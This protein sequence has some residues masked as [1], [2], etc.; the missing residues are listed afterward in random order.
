M[1]LRTI[2]VKKYQYYVGVGDTGAN[3]T[4]FTEVQPGIIQSEP[5]SFLPTNE[6]GQ[7]IG[8][9]LAASRPSYEMPPNTKWEIDNDLVD[10]TTGK[11]FFN[12]ND[13]LRFSLIQSFF[14]TTLQ[15]NVLITETTDRLRNQDWWKKS[16]TNED[17]FGDNLVNNYNY[18]LGNLLNY[19]DIN[20]PEEM[21]ELTL[22]IWMN[23]IDGTVHIPFL[24]EGNVH[25]NISREFKTYTM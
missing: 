11:V 14:R 25:P 21:N 15:G 13:R 6:Y 4:P 16:W 1:S 23:Q 17:P 8:Y 12:S 5:L 3:T 19:I 24:F 9:V 22:I 7:C 18:F 20:F 2:H 10:P